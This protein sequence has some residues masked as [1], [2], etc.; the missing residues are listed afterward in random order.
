MNKLDAA[1][2]GA[3]WNF[4][5]GGESGFL[6]LSYSIRIYSGGETRFLET[7]ENLKSLK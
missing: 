4:H 7:V 1:M 2:S 3:C 5:V 6:G